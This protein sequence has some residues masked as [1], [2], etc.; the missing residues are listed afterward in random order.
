MDEDPPSRE[1]IE[2]LTA[3][4]ALLERALSQNSERL[5]AIEG[6]L[7]GA[8]PPRPPATPAPPHTPPAALPTPPAAPVTPRA[9]PAAPDSPD[10]RAAAPPPPGQGAGAPTPPPGPEP[11]P[12]S[13]RPFGRGGNFSVFGARDSRQPAGAGQQPRGA[14]PAGRDL[15]SVIG[16]RAFAWVGIL[17]F[18]FGAAFFLKLA[19]ESGYVSPG[20]R[21]LAGA[22]VG[23][24]LLGT[25]ELL[26]GRGLRHYAFVISG[27]GILILYLSIYAAFNFYQLISQPA[28]FVLMAAVTTTAVLLSVRLD[29]LAVAVLGLVGGFLT[30]VL[31][32]TGRDNQVGLF[33][34]VALLD[35]GVLAL[36]YFKRWRSLYFLSFA[37][38]ALTTFGWLVIHYERPKLWLTL[39]FLTLFFALYALLAVAHN[40]L[41]RR[42]A[43][44][45]DL[46]LAAANAAVYF[47]LCYILLVDAGYEYAPAS[48]ALGVSAAYAA[49]FYLA[50]RLHR[51]DRLL[52]Y[53]FVGAAVTFFSVA[54]AVRLDLHWVTL[55][56]AVEALML[57]WAGLRAG[58]PAVRRAALPVFAFAVQHWF[59][60][61]LLAPF[62]G[63]GAGFQPLLN[64]R[65]LSCAVLVGALAAAAWLYRRAREVA[66][67][68]RAGAATLLTLAANG[69]ALVLLTQDLNEYF[70]RRAADAGGGA[71]DAGGRLESQRQFSLTVLWSVYGAGLLAFG[72]R[73]G[74]RWARYV[75]LA[76]LAVATIKAVAVDLSFYAAPWH[77]PVF[78]QTFTAF[79][80]LVVAY[81]V[82]ARLFARG[83]RVPE[84]ER[85]LA[86]VLTVVAHAL[87]VV[88]LSAEASGYFEA[89]IRAGELAGEA[90]PDLHLARQLS[91]SVIW[92]VYGGG[93]FAAGRAWGS[94]LLRV[95]ALVLLGLTAVKVFFW[96]LSS[97]DRVYRIVSF[98]LLGLIL[99][100]V[101]YLYQRSQQ[102]AEE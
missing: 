7:R 55:A 88:A 78:N 57:T 102:R 79:A 23:L 45:Y 34:Y 70:A 67:A 49:L 19:F 16:G 95:L 80:L 4:L 10:G 73:R 65:A 2:Q 72:A 97:L 81:A 56:W 22:V 3:R 11:A 51:A 47:G 87:A 31:L 101:S 44:W 15:E 92:A 38:T 14:A 71:P 20:V 99:L 77:V 82:A 13:G 9:S 39:F 1:S 93:L 90:L 62:A 85:A 58:E 76:L 69:L 98:V 21:V 27:G 84:E 24:A 40:L 91:L 61:D 25:G 83:E 63:D 8:T 32:S 37:A 17:A 96:D 100:A 30:P 54:V 60:F 41:P 42:P 53:A 86:P 12:S 52:A 28:A 48:H 18:A 59:L 74:A 29:A 75:G 33:A 50:Y 89:R 68:E 35:A 43:R 6:Y 5:S 64:R 46:L 26:R 94:R 36:A 66:E